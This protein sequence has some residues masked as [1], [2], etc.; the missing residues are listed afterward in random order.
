MEDKKISIVVPVYNV[1]KYLDK[2]ITHIISQTYSNL[3]ILLVDDGSRDSS[4][5]ICDEYAL[6]DSRIRVIHKDNGGSSSARNMGIHEATGDYI[7]FLDAD[8]WA[9][10]TM[11]ET[12]IKAALENNATICEVM[13]QDFSEDGELLKGPRLN[14]GNVTFIPREEDF[15]LLMMHLGD[16]SFCTKLIKAD[17]CKQFAFPENKLNEDFL[18]ILEMLMKC[19]GVYSIEE[20]HYSILI[21]NGSNQRSGF[22]P[23][24]YDAIIENS[25]FAYKL[26]EEN[27]PSCKTETERFRYVQRLMYLLHIPVDQMTKR[28]MTY[29]KVISEVRAGKKDW[30]SNPFLLPKEKRNLKILSVA[31][32]FS[33]HVHNVIM[34]FKRI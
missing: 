31:P 13:S 19:E 27:F 21:R 30:K 28:N 11:Y 34:K 1:E 15:R 2:T 7:G 12:L 25:D 18:L 6:K 29:Q 24:L 16:S 9:D 20:P 23:L 22:R 10:E 4:G 26:M 5:K 17:F 14:T 32:K 3:E 8:D 33:K